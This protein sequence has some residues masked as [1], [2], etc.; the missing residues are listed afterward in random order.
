MTDLVERYRAAMGLPADVPL[1][2][3]DVHAHWDLERRLTAELLAS[4]PET[5]WEV[6]ERAY[7]ELYGGAL[8]WLGGGDPEGE[9]TARR[10]EY[11]DWVALVGTDRPL[12]VYEVGAG[13]GGLARALAAAGH[14]VVATEVTKE[15]GARDADAPGLRWDVTDGVHLTRFTDPTSYD[16][17]V[18]SQVVEHLHPDDLVTHLHE[19]R[20]L[21][22][23]GG[24][25]LLTTPHRYDGP[26]DV[27]D[28]FGHEVSA[29]MHLKEYTYRELRRALRT[30]GWGQVASVFRPPQRVRGLPVPLLQ[31]PSTSAAY[32]RWLEVL[33]TVLGPLP[34]GRRRRAARYARLVGFRTVFLEARS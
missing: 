32:E 23:P 19:A 26:S 17:V 25:Y 31:R 7:T 27:S 11:G 33:E 21:V 8:P 14:R 12:D 10:G 22:R 30:A 9:L 16:V 2:E 5:R 18:S 34:H 4:T 13:S 24:R 15:R 20:A 29:G 6:F 3:Q 28:V 1:R